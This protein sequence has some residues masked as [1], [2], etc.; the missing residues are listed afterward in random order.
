MNKSSITND[1]AVIR[2]L[3]EDPAYAVE[4]LRAALEDESEPAVLTIALRHVTDAYGG[5]AK[6]A[7]DAG[8][9][10]EVLA[11]A[12]SP[13]GNPTVRTFQALIKALGMRMDIHRAPGAHA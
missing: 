4:Y 11:R 5:V 8:I 10:T 1:K 6:L 12:L 9:Q 3:R 7:E 2:E 13:K